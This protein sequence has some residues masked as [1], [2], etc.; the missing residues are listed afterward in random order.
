[1]ESTLPLNDQT[2]YFA[3]VKELLQLEAQAIA[4]VS[5]NLDPDQVQQAIE[6][7][8]TCQGKVVLSG[9][10]KSGIVA[11]KIAAT[12]SS[13]GT[14]SVFLHP[15]EALHGDLG[16]VNAQD[17]VI[18]LSN[19]GETD[20]LLAMLPSLKQR[21]VP[22]IALV[23]NI[24]STLA[25]RADVILAAPVE[26][27]ACPL[28]LAP[29]TSTTVAIAL[30]D[31]LAMTLMQAKGLTPNDFAF[32]HPAGRLGKRLTIHVSDLMHSEEENPTLP[33]DASWLAI[34]SAISQGGLGAVNVI[35]PQG[36]LLGIITDGDLRR[37]MGRIQ[38]TE[39][40]TMQAC[41][42]MTRNPIT[43]F[44]DQLAY[45]AL[46]LME[47]RPSQIA[48]LPVVDADQQCLGLIRLHDIARSGIL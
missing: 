33:P 36:R 25:R 7:L 40:D 28:N 4:Q 10:G 13:I 30:G 42:I 3:Q 9:I 26:H 12:L 44:P 5:E 34:V 16:I 17:I 18:A 6:L 37:A 43:V 41:G 48:V 15:V 27:E 35:D 8:K 32:N 1:M 47:N 19:S 39:L 31:A 46:K 21:N 24:N 38:V 22:L 11:R 2:S 23:G 45:D 29:T 20:E 14:A